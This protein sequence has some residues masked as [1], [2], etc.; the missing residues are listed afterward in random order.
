[1]SVQRVV[2]VWEGAF[3]AVFTRTAPTAALELEGVRRMSD[4][5]LRLAANSRW[6]GRN[7]HGFAPTQDGCKCGSPPFMDPSSSQ[8][9]VT[10]LRRNPVTN[11][12]V[13]VLSQ[14]ERESA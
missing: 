2:S 4:A 13:L 1:V 11:V 5:Q 10:P 3:A 12:M 8:G 9:A 6:H 7:A 14:S